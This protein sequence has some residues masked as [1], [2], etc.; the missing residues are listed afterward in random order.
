MPLINYW[1]L[2]NRQNINAS[3]E[4]SLNSLNQ[5]LLDLDKIINN[6]KE[7]KYTYR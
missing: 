1:N 7:R 3:A 6:F 5:Y 4:K 2:F